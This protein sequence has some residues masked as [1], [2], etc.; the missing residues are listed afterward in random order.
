[1]GHISPRHLVRLSLPSVSDAII[2]RMRLFGNISLRILLWSGLLS[3]VPLA[4]V[5]ADLIVVANEHA[6]TLS[7]IDHETG[8]ATRTLKLGGDP[9][10]WLPRT[11]S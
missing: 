4:G 2:L 9:H 5:S 11:E 8:G 7:I 10:R 3:L 6:G 1:M